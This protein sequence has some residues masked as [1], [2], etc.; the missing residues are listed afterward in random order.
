MRPLAPFQRGSGR[1]ISWIKG[2]IIICAVLLLLHGARVSPHLPSLRAS[3]SAPKMYTKCPHAP[4]AYA[5]T[6]RTRELFLRTLIYSITGALL[7]TPSLEPSLG[8][9]AHRPQRPYNASQ[10]LVG[11]D[12]PLYGLSMTGIRRMENLKELLQRV[13]LHDRVEGD[14][15][16]L[17]TWRGGSSLFAKAFLDASALAGSRHV[18]LFDSFQGLP[19]ASTG[20]GERE[21]GLR[22]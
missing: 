14:F 3:E 12:W 5:V 10:R 4:P 11:S 17:G 2:F 18:H 6:E 19:Q 15:V 13:L 16:E 21:T 9:V 8:K 22:G 1:S 7:R 20:H